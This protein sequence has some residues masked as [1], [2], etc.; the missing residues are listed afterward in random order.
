MKKHSYIFLFVL[1]ITV[2]A[3]ISARAINYPAIPAPVP[4]GYMDLDCVTL[5]NGSLRSASDCSASYRPPATVG[6]LVLTLFSLAI[7]LGAFLA[8]VSL[9]YTGGQFVFSGQNPGIRVAA[10][11]RLQNVI[12]GI[13]ILLF[14]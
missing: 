6:T 5:P 9:I 4:G 12:M 3:P 1:L 13:L 7:W 10:R 8:L 11:E 2:L 14:T